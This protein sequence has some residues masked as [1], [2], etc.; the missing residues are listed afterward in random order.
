MAIIQW[1][2]IVL[3]RLCNVLFIL[4][5]IL[6]ESMKNTRNTFTKGMPGD[7]IRYID[8]MLLYYIL[9]VKSAFNE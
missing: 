1:E 8:C 4:L 6:S 2:V 9:F 3:T 5:A 7:I